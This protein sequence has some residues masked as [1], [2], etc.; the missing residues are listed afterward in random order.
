M[1]FSGTV[2]IPPSPFS[3][4]V[5]SVVVLYTAEFLITLILSQLKFSTAFH[6]TLTLSKEIRLNAV[7]T[8][9]TPGIIASIRLPPFEG[10]P[11]LTTP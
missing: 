5:R 7:L 2:D 10:K 4:L 6:A 3:S 11:C 1:L 9:Y 8:R